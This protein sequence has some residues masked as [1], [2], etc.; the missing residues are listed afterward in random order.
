MYYLDCHREFSSCED[1]VEVS[2]KIFQE[3]FS[4]KLNIKLLNELDSPMRGQ[5]LKGG[6]EEYTSCYLVLKYFCLA[7]LYLDKLFEDGYRETVSFK[8]M[9]KLL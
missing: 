4:G 9:E 1:E 2:Q 6:E 3:Y 5:E 8:A 7:E